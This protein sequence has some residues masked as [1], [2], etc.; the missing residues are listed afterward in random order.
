MKISVLILRGEFCDRPRNI[1]IGVLC[2]GYRRTPAWA[3][4][5]L[6]LG[7]GRP[8]HG[9]SP[10]PRA[11]GCLAG[12]GPPRYRDAGAATLA[13]GAGR[14]SESAQ[15]IPS[16]NHLKLVRDCEILLFQFHRFL[17]TLVDEGVTVQLKYTDKRRWSHL[18]ACQSEMCNN[19]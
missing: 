11:S 4:R 16:Q 5:A 1:Q 14:Y 8:D 13:A 19:G 18:Q 17:V 2:S 6:G 15:R 7:P 12:L 3:G 10:I 9:P